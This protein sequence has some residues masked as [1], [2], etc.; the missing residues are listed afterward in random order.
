MKLRKGD[1]V[2]VI[3][4]KDRGKTGAIA[5]VLVQD[6]KVIVT[7]INISKHHLKPSRKNPHGGILDMP[8][9]MQGSNVMIICPHCGKP[10]KIGTNVTEKSKERVCRKCKGNLDQKIEVKEKNAK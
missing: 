6:D 4:G 1:N 8:A 7:G 3:A 2:F 5:K 10:T 9:P